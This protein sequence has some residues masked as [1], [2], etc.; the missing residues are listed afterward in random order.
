[1]KK[2]VSWLRAL[3]G[4]GLALAAV[5]FAALTGSAHAEGS[6]TH[7]DTAAFDSAVTSFTTDLQTLVGKM[8]P[9]IV[10]IATI[11]LIIVAVN[12]LVRKVRGAIG[13]G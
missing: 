9:A 6:G 11:T 5:A 10:T 7:V 8:A 2:F 1:M 13:R 3:P 4:K 12:W